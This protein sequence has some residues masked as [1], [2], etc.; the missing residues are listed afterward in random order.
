MAASSLSHAK[1]VTASAMP[2]ASYVPLQRSKTPPNTQVATEFLPTNKESMIF[3]SNLRSPHAHGASTSPCGLVDSISTGGFGGFSVVQSA[4]AHAT[5]ASP[6][7]R[8]VNSA[9]REVQTLSSAQC[10][11]VHAASTSP[12]WRV[13]SSP[14]SAVV[15]SVHVPA[16]NPSYTARPSVSYSTTEAGLCESDVPTPKAA[17]AVQLDTCIP[18]KMVIYRC[19]ACNE[20][21]S[22]LD[23]ALKHCPA[24]YC[25]GTGSSQS[26]ARVL[27]DGDREFQQVVEEPL[28]DGEPV[29][30]DD[31]GRP[32]IVRWVDPDSGAARTVVRNADGSQRGFG[33]S[34]VAS[35]LSANSDEAAKWA[36]ALAQDLTDCEVRGLSHE[37]GQR[38]LQSSQLYQRRHAE[39]ENLRELLDYRFFGLSGGA[40]EKELDNAYRQC[41]KKMHPDKNGGT[42]DA[43]E[44]FQRMRERY[45]TLKKKIGL[46]SDLADDRAGSASNGCSQKS[47]DDEEHLDVRCAGRSV[48]GAAED[49]DSDNIGEGSKED[50]PSA[51]FDRKDRDSMVRMVSRYA[52]QLKDINAKMKVLVKELTRARAQ[53]EQRD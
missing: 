43:K 5:S 28:P 23:A 7:G 31:H 48:D 35:L 13:D 45:E 44:R 8:G 6:H 9:N 15:R 42:D 24:I 20:F 38:L 16:Q 33:E 52:Q 50:A 12:C 53:A 47:N 39:L 4:E 46:P 30:F 2:A 21:V 10:L 22:S 3:C 41:A 51:G 36:A 27:D 49:T 19:P 1:S 40:S 14:G 25:N 26:S 32:C 18:P 11:R 34:T 29:A 37:L 17:G